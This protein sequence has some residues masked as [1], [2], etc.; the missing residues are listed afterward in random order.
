MHIMEQDPLMTKKDVQAYLHIS[1]QTLY[2]LMKRGAFSYFKLDRKV[3]FRK[4]AIDAYLE[5]HLV[6][7]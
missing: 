2:T 5:Q 3:L 7:K 1:H 4:S 6:K